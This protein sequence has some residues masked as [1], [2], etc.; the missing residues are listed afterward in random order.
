MPNGSVHR[1]QMAITNTKLQTGKAA[2]NTRWA[3]MAEKFE[4]LGAQEKKAV[5]YAGLFLALTIVYSLYLKSSLNLKSCS[6]G[7]EFIMINS[8]LALAALKFSSSPAAPARSW[9][10]GTRPGAAMIPRTFQ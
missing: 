7:T 4:S 9:P 6:T 8:T 1:P 3:L 5:E 2:L 10:P